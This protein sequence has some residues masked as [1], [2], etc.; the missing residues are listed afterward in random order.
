MP[1][2]PRRFM[3]IADTAVAALSEYCGKSQRRLVNLI[4]TNA[5]LVVIEGEAA[6][7]ARLCHRIVARLDEAAPGDLG[8]AHIG[9]Y[10]AHPALRDDG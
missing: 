10:P 5:P 6:H 2:Q 4:N 7:L 8:A 3:P 9:N 1:E